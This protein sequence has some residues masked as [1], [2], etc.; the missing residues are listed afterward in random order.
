MEKIEIDNKDTII[1]SLI[2]VIPFIQSLLHMDSMFAV[3]DKEK[4]L[5]Y[6]PGKIINPDISLGSP[7]PHES[8]LYKCQKTDEK[9]S[10]NLPKEV[11]GI[12]TK[13]SSIPIKD[14]N[15]NIIGALSIG[16]NIDTQQKLYESAQAIA[17]TTEEINATTEESAATAT[18]LAEDLDFLKKSGEDIMIE[19]QKTSEILKFINEIARSSNLLGLNSAIEA[20]RAGEHGRGFTVV[21]K[22]IRKMAD[23][24]SKS[25]KDVTETIKSIENSISN[26]AKTLLNTAQLGDTQAAITEEISASMQQLTATALEL[27]KIAEKF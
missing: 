27:E 1:G 26:I 25:V 19:I 8:G 18:K 20:A 6:L 10:L 4:F 16:L 21:A 22:E 23:N 13:T 12:P 2:R 24:S 3:V 14:D 17:A 11:Y 5:Y 7:I 15:G 9:I